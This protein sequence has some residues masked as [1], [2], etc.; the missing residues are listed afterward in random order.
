MM[1]LRSPAKVSVSE[2][3][4]FLRL[5]PASHFTVCQVQHMM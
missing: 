5:L 3:I 1:T 2:L 4:H